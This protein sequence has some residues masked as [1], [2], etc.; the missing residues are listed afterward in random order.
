MLGLGEQF[1][2]TVRYPTRGKVERL[3][4]KMSGS[5]GVRT[6]SETEPW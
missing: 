6:E 2:F 5:P 3:W 4:M 1:H